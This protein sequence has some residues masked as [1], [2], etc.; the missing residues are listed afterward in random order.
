MSGTEALLNSM[1]KALV[2]LDRDGVLNLLD[3]AL[4]AGI[5]PEMIIGGDGYSSNGHDIVLLVGRLLT[6]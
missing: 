1:E 2:A 4:S 6:E 5:T 3:E